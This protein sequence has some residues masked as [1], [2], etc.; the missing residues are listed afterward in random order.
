VVVLA[1]TT[2]LAVVVVVVMMRLL[3]VV[4]DA[5]DGECE[6]VFEFFQFSSLTDFLI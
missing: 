6:E 1:A 2:V 5:F 4:V 3:L